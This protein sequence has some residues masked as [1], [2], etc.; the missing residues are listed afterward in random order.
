M[1]IFLIG[2]YV[3]GL[4]LHCLY[5]TQRTICKNL[6]SPFTMCVDPGDSISGHQV[7][8]GAPLPSLSHLSGPVDNGVYL[9]LNFCF[10]CMYVYVPHMCSACRGQKTSGALELELQVAV[11]CQ[12]GTEPGSSERTASSLNC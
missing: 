6:F 11:S 12:V 1:L 2:V 3:W 10:M 7:G 4:M 9:T 5:G 8:G